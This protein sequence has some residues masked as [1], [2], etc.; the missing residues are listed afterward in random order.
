MNYF[1]LL[2]EIIVICI[3]TVMLI[4]GTIRR[5]R[6]LIFYL[7]LSAVLSGVLVLLLINPVSGEGGHLI[8][9]DPVVNLI[10]ILIYGGGA[11]IL[12]F[13]FYE[14][15]EKTDRLAEFYF[16]LIMSLSGM[17]VLTMANDLL[18]IY[19]SIELFSL[20]FYILAAFYRE[21]RRSIEAGM[22]YFVLGTLSSIVLV[23]SIAFFYAYTGSTSLE[24]LRGMNMDSKF[25]IFG[26]LLFLSAFAFKLSLVPFHA[27][28]PDVYE[29][30][31][32]SVTALFASLPKLA[33]F[34]LLGKIFS[35]AFK[36]IDLSLFIIIVS[37]LSMILGNVLALRQKN[38][39]RMLSYSSI[40]H[41]GYMFT[42]FL[43]PEQ[44]IYTTLVPYLIFYLFMNLG[45]FAVILSIEKG[46]KIDSFHGLNNISPVLALSMAI[47]M[48]SFTG[49]PPTA[50]FIVKFNLF[51]NV[52]LAGYGGVVFLGIFMSILSAYYYLRVVFYSYS[53]Q[54]A[55]FS[56]RKE[57]RV[58][59]VFSA[60]LVLAGG[61]FPSIYLL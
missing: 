60:F 28:S 23:G 52:F 43:L 24:S 33:V 35:L 16:L 31:P 7:S 56:L 12:I 53:S 10:R 32:T 1:S 39:K 48:L 2:P 26:S 5:E 57:L 21:D 11:F 19:L 37:S 46:E 6:H 13:S 20:C 38:L 40:A 14:L 58:C 50:G 45:A 25:T 51:K 34:I 8:Q 9:T 44:E 30:A 29:G 41:S 49:I 22:K 15:S 47:V 4:A 3:A 27:W 59:A 61:V 54:I 55:E 42:A 17:S 18:I 36:G